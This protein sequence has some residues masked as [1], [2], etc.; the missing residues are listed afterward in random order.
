M[1]VAPPAPT[2]LMTAEDLLRLPMGLGE[3][4]ELVD[5]GLQTISPA[6]PLHGRIAV[7]VGGRL[8]AHVHRKK[9]G[10]VYGAETGFTLRRN[11][12]TVRAPDAAFVG[13]TRLP[14]GG[15]ARGYFPGAPDLA[16]EVMSPDDSAEDINAKIHDNFEAGTQ[17]VWVVYPRTQE[18]QVFTSPRASIVLG[19]GDTLEGGDLPPGFACPVAEVFE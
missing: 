11:P 2:P 14:K 8:D 1:I 10:A 17:Q 19:L 4:Y 3:R 12:D 7:R 15:V 9:L 18:I 16:V 6:G 13:K 5:G